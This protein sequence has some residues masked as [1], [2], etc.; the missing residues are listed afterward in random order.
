M[1][2]A[3]RVSRRKFL[4]IVYLALLLLALIVGAW[5][6]LRSASTPKQTPFDGGRAYDHVL[7]QMAFGPRVMGSEAHGKTVD[8]I[9]DQLRQAGWATDTQDFTYKGVASTNIIARAAL[10]RGPGVIVGAH[11]DSRR[12]ADQ[13]SAQPAAPVPGANDGA[14]GVAVLL[15]LARTLD[16]SKLRNEVWLAF[17]DAEDDGGLEG[18]DWIVGSTYMARTLEVNPAYVVVL[19][20]IGEA[21]QQI[22]FDYNSDPKLSAQIWSIA[23]GLGYGQQFVPLP[24]YSMLDD[25]TPFAARGIPAVDIIDFDYPYWHTT[26]DT[27]D[28]VSPASLERVGRTIQALLEN[29]Q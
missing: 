16:A 21:D 19:D 14:S 12:R 18:W 26:G 27:A 11:Y 15:E 2:G 29:E 5:L 20:M 4:L 8:Y 7:A 23:G 13:E 28:K 1:E 22:F 3:S 6:L 24:K 17:F 25:H 10:G 9:L